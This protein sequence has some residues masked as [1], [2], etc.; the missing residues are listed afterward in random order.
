M[1]TIYKYGKLTQEYHV[2][3][4]VINQAV[5]VMGS[6]R[7]KFYKKIIFLKIKGFNQYFYPQVQIAKY[8]IVNLIYGFSVYW[9][10]HLILTQFFTYALR[11]IEY[12]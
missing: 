3:R 5:H 12:T 4:Q 7:Y 2:Y 9:R 1:I 10:V 11:Y 6:Y 8:L